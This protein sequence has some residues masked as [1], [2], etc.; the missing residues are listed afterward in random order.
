LRGL[1]EVALLKEIG[2]RFTIHPLVL[3]DIAD[4]FQRPKF[5]EFDD[6][7]FIS[8]CAIH[9]DN[10]FMLRQEYMAIFGGSRFVLTF[11]QTDSDEFEQIRK[12]ISQSKGRIRQRN[13]D[14]LLYALLD[15]VVDNYFIFLDVLGER[16]EILEHDLTEGNKTGVRSKIY[17]YKS[18]IREI[19]KTILPL[20][21]AISKFSR[22]DSD[23]L[24][25][26]TKPYLRDLYDHISDV[27][28]TL[29]TY[30]ESL[31]HIQEHYASN[32]ASR[33]NQ[34]MQVLTIIATIFIPLTFIAGVYGMNFKNM[35]ELEWDYGYFTVLT[36][37]LVVTIGMIFFFKRKNWM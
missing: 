20:K 26:R 21:D 37:M 17:Q 8:F 4:I 10:D 19:R 11:Q 28:A 9:F 29:D 5:E 27:T 36:L 24:E 3:E 23:L 33:T 32:I 13:A 34:V 16:I 12:R 1:H 6:G 18:I 30:R 15:L 35:P 25:K 31:I 14:Y 22:T 7:F 2:Q